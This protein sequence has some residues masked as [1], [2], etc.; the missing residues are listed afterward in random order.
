M[1]NKEDDIDAAMGTLYGELLAAF[2]EAKAND[3]RW[4]TC[5]DLIETALAEVFPGIKA[6][7]KYADIPF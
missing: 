1:S 7:H 6:K 4:Y 2:R 3:L 5:E